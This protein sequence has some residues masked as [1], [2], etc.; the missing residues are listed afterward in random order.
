LAPFAATAAA[1]TVAPPGGTEVG[2]FASAAVAA[3]TATV[4][5]AGAIRSSYCSISSLRCF[6]IILSFFYELLLDPTTTSGELTTPTATS[7]TSASQLLSLRRLGRQ[8]E[9]PLH[10]SHYGFFRTPVHIM[11]D[12]VSVTL[13]SAGENWSAPGRSRRRSSGLRGPRGRRCARTV[14][15]LLKGDDDKPLAPWQ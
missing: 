13:S 1:L 12:E 5:V 6:S 7:S 14:V 3:G 15:R 2:G 10:P 9:S 8:T 11:G 4:S